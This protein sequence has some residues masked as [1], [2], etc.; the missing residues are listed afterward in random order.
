[1]N[2]QLPYWI[3]VGA[4]DRQEYVKILNLIREHQLNTICLEANCPNRYRCF[5]SGT[6][7]FLILG[8]VCTRNCAYCNVSHGTPKGVD[9]SEPERIAQAVKKLG[10]RHAVI[11]SVSRDDLKDGGASQFFETASAIRKKSPKCRIELLIPDFQGSTSALKRV[12][13]SNP[14]VLNHNIEAVKELF[15]KLRPQGSYNRSIKL[16][17]KAKTLNSKLITKSGLMLGFG[18]SL[19]QVFETLHDLKDA[20]CDILTIGQYLQPSPNK[21]PVQKFYKPSEFELIKREALKLGF[22]SVVS[23]PLVRSSYLAEQSFL[24]VASGSAE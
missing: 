22:K 7:T 4:Y 21:I 12:L 19:P 24:E 23:G 20:G 10:L 3:G 6:A 13:S 14:E 18:E 2:R 11:T 5:S 9:R 1:M 8:K 16:L 17:K 15:P